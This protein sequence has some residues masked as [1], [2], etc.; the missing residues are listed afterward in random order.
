[1]IFPTAPA[2]NLSILSGNSLLTRQPGNLYHYFTMPF[3]YSSY[4]AHPPLPHESFVWEDEPTGFPCQKD[5]IFD[6]AMSR[7][8]KFH[9]P[10]GIYFVSFAVVEWIDVFTRNEYKDIILNSLMYCQKEKGMEVFAWCIMTNHI[11]LIYRSIKS[12][13]PEQVLGDLKRF[14]S[15]ALVRAIKDNPDESRKEWMLKIFK[16]S[17]KKSSNV[18]NYQFWRHDNKPIELWSNKVME[19]KLDYIHNNP[20]NEGIVSNPEDYLYS[21]ARDY[22]GLNGLLDGVVVL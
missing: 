19:E 2:G 9:N 3:T 11:H 14:T 7:N 20:V 15:K 18:N 1:L 22:S 4:T 13:K 6:S 8:Y 10:E 12:E 17:A 16:T 5:L 21:S